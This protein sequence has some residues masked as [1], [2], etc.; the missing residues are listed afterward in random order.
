[1]NKPTYLLSILALGLAACADEPPTPAEVRARIA[2]DLAHVLTEANAASQV[3]AEAMPAGASMSLIDRMLGES[4]TEVVARMRTKLTAFVVE[5]RVKQ[6]L[7]R[8]T[9]PEDPVEPDPAAEAV[10]ALNNEL[11]TDANHLGEGVFRIPAELVCTTE[12]YDDTTGEFVESVDPECAAELDRAQVRIRVTADD[13]SMQFAL[14][15]TEEKEQPVVA[16]LEA[17][18]LAVTVD[19]DDAWRSTSALAA[20]D[21]EELPNAELSGQVTG[22][23]AILGTAHAE[24]SLAIDRD[25][26]IKLAEANQSLDGAEAFRFTSKQAEVFSISA[27]GPASSGAFA[28]GL[29]ATSIHAPTYFDDG[30]GT[31]TTRAME[32]DLAAATASATFSRGQPLVVENIG[33]GDRDLVTKLGGQVASRIGINPDSG[34]AFAMTLTDDT[35]TGRATIAFAPQLDLRT[36]TDH[37][38][39]GTEPV[40]YDITRVL[41]TGTLSTDAASSTVKVESGTYAIETNPVDFGFTA[42]AGQCVTASEAYDETSGSYYTTFALATCN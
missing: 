41:V 27:N 11:F 39:A 15:V 28:L 10:N 9:S 16:T 35:S 37:A 18:S 4:D 29:G 7:A 20:L 2:S 36:F 23:L 33:L 22:K 6:G 1:M 40:V 30:S 19:L 14:Q 32:I 13:D 38:V 3:A 8:L 24:V 26:S 21:G 17:Q 5:Q 42:T 12:T 34:R 31:P 25:V